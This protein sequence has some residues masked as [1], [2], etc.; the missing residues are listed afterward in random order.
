MVSDANLPSV[1]LFQSLSLDFSAGD[2]GYVDNDKLY[3]EISSLNLKK[4]HLRLHFACFYVGLIIYVK[5]TKRAE[6]QLLTQRNLLRR[7][8]Q[9]NKA[10]SLSPYLPEQLK[11]V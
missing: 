11:L 10:V 5:L 7:H 6:G 9:G 2:P 1:S 3:H 4:V 8:R